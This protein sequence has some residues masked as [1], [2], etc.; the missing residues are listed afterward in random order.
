MIAIMCIGLKRHITTTYENHN[1]VFKILDKKFGIKIYDFYREKDIPNCP[2]PLTNQEGSGKLQMYD[3]ITSLEKVDEEIIVKF[4]S[5]IF[6]TDVAIN[7]LISEIEKIIN[8]ENDLAYL[9]LDFKNDYDQTYKITDARKEEKITDFVIVAKKSLIPPRE[10]I[11]NFLFN[12][13]KSLYESS[14][15]IVFFLLINSNTRA[16]KISTQMYLI[17]KDYK[18]LNNWQIY[19]DWCHDYKHKSLHAFNWVKNNKKLIN[20]F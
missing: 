2:F 16:T 9:G 20:S 10:Y 8:N 7:A 4:R 6:F 17:R 5:D 3:F 14:G 1:K 19:F 12:H 18:T 13:F 11:I 15:N